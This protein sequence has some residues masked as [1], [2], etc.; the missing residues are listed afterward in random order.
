MWRC[1]IS[2]K[3]TNVSQEGTKSIFRV[4]EWTKQ[5][6]SG[7]R[8]DFGFFFDLRSK[9]DLEMYWRDASL[10]IILILLMLFSLYIY[11]KKCNW[12][13]MALQLRNSWT[14]PVRTVRC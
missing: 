10:K 3:V 13:I 1:L 14:P 11:Q 12:K 6:A 4:E 9:I 2:Q 7:K 5:H 8:S